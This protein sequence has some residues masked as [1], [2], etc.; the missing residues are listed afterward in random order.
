MYL[1]DLQSKLKRL[2]NRLIV[3]TDQPRK[4]LFGI[5]S[6][7][8]VLAFG[9]R[10]HRSSNTARY[11]RLDTDARRYME[12]KQ[13]GQAGEYMGGVCEYVPEYDEFDIESGQLRF[14]GWR[15]I[16]YNLVLRGACTLDR[17]RKVF[18]CSS[19]GETDW[20]KL[21]SEQKL[22]WVRREHAK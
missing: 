5:T 16:A 20:D 9:K 8:I 3:Q 22:A 12:M 17:A 19:L 15:S 4:I 7:P 21:P 6:Y 18:N 13:S 14:R 11:D 10:T 2:N 1:F